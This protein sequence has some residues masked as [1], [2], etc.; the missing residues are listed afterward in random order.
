[1]AQV[2][3]S[4]ARNLDPAFLFTPLSPADALKTGER[5]GPLKM[6]KCDERK[7]LSRKPEGSQGLE[8]S[9]SN[10]LLPEVWLDLFPSNMYIAN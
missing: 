8:H 2:D 7:T 10:S 9:F 4:P 3:G 1:M 6:L 5:S